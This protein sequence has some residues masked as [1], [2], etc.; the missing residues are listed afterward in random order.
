M[1]RLADPVTAYAEKVCSGDIVAG[2]WVNLA[3]ERHLSDLEKLKPQGYKW[4]VDLAKRYIEFFHEV[5][6]LPEGDDPNGDPLPFILE[7]WQQF[8][9]GSLFGWLAPDGYRRYRTAYVE[10]PKGMGKSPMG[11]GVG[12]AGL[13]ADGESGAQIYS[14]ATTRDQAKIV[15][16]DADKMRTRSDELRPELVRT[17]NNLAFMPT[18][19]FF[20]PVSADASKLDGLRPHMVIV[21]EIHEHRTSEVIDKMRAGFKFR[22][23]PLMFEITNSGVDRTSVCYQHHEYSVQILK[24]LIEND[25]WFAYVCALDGCDQHE[26]ASPGCPDCDDPMTDESVWPKVAPNLGVSVQ[27]PYIRDMVREAQGMPAKEN[28]TRRLLFCQWTQQVTRW[29][30]MDRWDAC[31]SRVDEPSLIG[32]QCFGGLDLASTSDI[33]AWIL[34]FPD[35]DENDE[36]IYD[37]LCRF[38]VPQ[39]NIMKRAQ[40]DR[41]PYDA[42]ERDGYVEATPGNVIDYNFIR[43]RIVADADQFMLRA[44]GFDPWNATQLATQ[45]IEEDGLPFIQ[46]RQGLL[47]MNEPS[48]ELERLLA[49]RKLCHG[50]HPVLRWMANNVAI[51]TDASGNIRPD[52]ERSTEKID[53]I[54]ALITGLSRAMLAVGDGLSKYEEEDLIVI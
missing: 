8:I 33:A 51:R 13:V 35:Q 5:L 32:R 49:S 21:D 19:S 44:A 28:I 38:F 12:L 17:V 47:S 4:S 6:V 27:A 52:K 10:C 23:Q 3:C 53:G 45:L 31:D 15:W 50:G 26:D 46:V 7:P 37:V 34:L 1:V 16:G 22:K 54:T 39:D 2:P 40:T 48:K 25:T 9:I 14:A 41:V 24:G 43:K 30:D 42:W 29:I 18:A 20:R 36:T 11:A